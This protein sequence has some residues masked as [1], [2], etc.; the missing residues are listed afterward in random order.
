[1]KK[2]ILSALLV[3][4]LLLGVLAGCSKK[5]TQTTDDTNKNDQSSETA[6]TSSQ[7]AYQAQFLDLPEDIQWIGSSCVAGDLLYFSASV[8]DGGKETYT[9]ENG[10]EVSYD[11]YSE[12]IFRMDLSTGECTKLE[13]YEAEPVIE[14][15]TAA[16]GVTMGQDG[17]MIVYNSSTNISTMAA[18]AD[19]TIW[20]YRQTNR[21]S[22]DGSS[23][24]TISELIQLDAHGTLLRTITPV[25]D[26]ASD[27]TDD[28]YYTY[29]SDIFSDDKGYVYTYD[30][31][32]LNVYGP[33][34]TFVCGKTGDE[35]NGQVCQF[36]ASEVGVT[37]V[38]ADDKSVFKQLDPET[39]DWGKETPVSSDAWNLF[40]GND[41]YAYFY[42]RNGSI[43]GERKD[44]GK[45]EKVVDWMSCDVDS[46]SISSDNIAFLSD[47]R[48]A[49]VT[50]DYNRQDGTNTQQV[51]VLTRVDASSVKQKTEL[52]LACY[53]L[54]YNLRSQ[55]VK[56]N[57]NN[58]E[59]RIVVKDYSELSSGDGADGLTK[60]NTE[61]ISGNVPDL[62][63][64][65]Q[66]PIAQYA[67]KG[68]LEDL[69]SYIDA[70]P[71]YSRDALM[72]QPI[73]AAQT[74]GHL[75]Q[76]PID[77]GVVTAIGLNKVV[78]GYTSWTLAD[79]NDALSKLPEGATVFNK[80]YTQAEML[81]YCVAM[82]ASNFMNWQDG[83]CNFDS[84][85]FRALL[86]FVKPM[87]ADFDWQSD[88]EDYESDYSRVRNGKQLLYP[89]SISDFDNLY[90][91]FAALN[92]DA[93][94]I[95]FP[96]EDGSSGNC[97]ASQV[98]LAIT[99][100]CKDKSAAW[101]FIRS[102][103]SDDYQTNM[104]SFPIV[105]S[106]FEAQAAKAMEQEYETDADGNQVLDENGNPIPIST[107]GM[108]YGDEPMIELYAVTQ[109]QYD[110]VMDV[111]NTTTSYLDYDTN[112][113]VTISQEAAAYFSGD[114]TVEEVSKLIQNRVSLYMQE[115]K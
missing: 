43:Y 25:S 14:D 63:M 46:N 40:P 66:L 100:A 27:N 15:P 3:L 72:L 77:F 90:Y 75:Y 49:A 93:A 36:S 54:D 104:W 34:G 79:V 112:V 114:K 76:M 74:D 87:P 84:D 52:T 107:G 95:G 111:I 91:T 109:E 59:Y 106:A 96:R 80:Y 12:A 56:F 42:T 55:I 69:W 45:T 58:S 110:A 94:F 97:F 81:Q 41:V 7:Y 71:E 89:T 47:G 26:D 33:D 23:D 4:V 64:T 82:N 28:W 51:V 103:L 86:E 30:Y 32:T 62:M 6:E 92:N 16:D 44:T 102:T 115:Q 113:L 17:S 11:T 31:Q 101:S 70:D 73:N 2:R 37:S 65:N 22:S 18:G 19:G 85:E 13:N 50:S 9:D 21:Y 57:K 60:L 38:S 48:I 61:I 105:K 39:K 108:S 83:T 88:D 53:G 24:E 78:G 67:A 99:T 8:P 29:I 35:L 20:L 98:S 68:L 1:M 10:Q 5:D